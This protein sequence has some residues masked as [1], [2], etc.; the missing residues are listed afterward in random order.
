MM[1]ARRARVPAA[2][3]SSVCLLALAGVSY[4]A[5]SIRYSGKTSQQQPVSLKLSGGKV[6]SLQYH[7]EDRCPRGKLLFVHDY[8]FPPIPI[9]QS[10]FSGRFEARPPQAATATV[11]GVVSG[12]TVSGSLMDRTTNRKTHK[13]CTGKATF[14]LKPRSS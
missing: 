6:R 5:T 10:K 4:A 9:K 1:I 7:I 2:A 3:L 11:A 12:R 8:G 13:L 14:R